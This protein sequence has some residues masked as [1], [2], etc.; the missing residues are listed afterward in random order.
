MADFV[1]ELR[2]SGFAWQVRL[3]H[4]PVQGHGSDELIARAIETLVDVDVDVVVLVRGGG[5]RLDLAVFDSEVL[6]RAIA[7]SPVPVLTGIGHE[8]DTSVA[9]VA[10]HSSYKT[11]TACASA[12]VEQV[13]AGL[14]RAEQAWSA[15]P[16]LARS[17]AQRLDAELTRELRSLPRGARARVETAASRVAA[18]SRELRRQSARRLDDEQARLGRLRELVVPTA[19]RVVERAERSLAV[20]E[21]STDGADP[22]RLMRRGWSITRTGAGTVVRTTSDVAPGDRLTTSV[23]DGSIHSDVTHIVTGNGATGGGSP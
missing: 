5:S 7:A 3:A 6:G 4:V 21:A 18:S 22:A 12:L 9:D 16:A 11:P 10:A 23:A 14:H 8:I 2:S 17:S 20:L 15:I 1:D 19:S 13:A